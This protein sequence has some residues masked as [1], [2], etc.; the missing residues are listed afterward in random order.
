V[1]P[2]GASGITWCVGYDGGHQTRHVIAQDWWDH[3]EVMR[4]ATTAGL[5]GQKARAVLP[6]Y[7]NILTPYPA[8]EKVFG[9]RTLIEYERR[10]ARWLRDGYAD[11]P[12]NC[13]G[14]LVA[15]VYN[16]G[17]STVGD[18]R[19]EMKNIEKTCVP[20]HDCKCVA[21]EN[22]ASKRVWKGSSI[23]AGMWRR[24]DEESELME[25]D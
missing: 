18:N 22:R 15:L 1:W 2:G 9:E 14:G 23:Q 19:R 7:R 3:P 16:R 21:N 10:T 12:P 8:C 4:L 20:A 25:S 6:Q 11:L 24:R 5:T 17:T 13:K